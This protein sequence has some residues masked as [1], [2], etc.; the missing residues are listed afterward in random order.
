ML[1]NFLTK[2]FLTVQIRWFFD[3]GKMSEEKNKKL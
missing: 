1:P 3:D 2:D